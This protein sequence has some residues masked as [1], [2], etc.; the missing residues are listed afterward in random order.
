[1]ATAT[2]PAPTTGPAAPPEVQHVTQYLDPSLIVRDACNARETDPAP[3][4]KL[5]NSVKTLGVQEPISV[6]P[7]GDGTYGA[8]KGWRRA[9]A[10]Q[11]ANDTAADEQREQRP[12]PA[13]VHGE[14]VG[15]DDWTRFLSLVENDH[16]EGMDAR[17]TLKAAELSLVGMDEVQRKV[18]AKAL[19]LGR[20]A[21]QQVKR[22]QKLT[23]AELRRASAGGMDL[24]QT[25]Q[26][27][28][29]SEIRNAERRLLA[30]LARDQEEGKGGR[31]HWDQEINA[32]HAEM[33]DN[34]KR[35]A[36]LQALKDADIPVL[37]SVYSYNHLPE[38]DRPR[39][40]SELMTNLGNTLTEEAH[41]GCAGHS[42]RLD[43]EHQPVWHCMEPAKYGHKVRPE[44]RQPKNKLSE[45]ERAERANTVARNR[46]WKAA[47]TMRQNYITALA[48]SSKALPE[49]A[50]VFAQTTLVTMPF[51]YAAFTD[52]NTV[53]E[54]APYLGITADSYDEAVEAIT[55]LPKSKTA[56]VMFAQVAAAYE[57][58]LRE[59]KAWASLHPKTAQWLLLL[60]ELGKADNGVYVL[61][62]V[63]AD[64]VASHR[65]KQK[66]TGAK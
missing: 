32:L 30:A 10:A 63:E 13:F 9:Q 56:H 11:I 36:A 34:T 40:L 31:G 58:A 1:M 57:Y 12:I 61:S 51:F 66:K 55:A 19:G 64:A 6:R 22:A 41:K 42:A 50:R 23:D 52:K 49:A 45:K 14:L 44:A 53:K 43:D 35:D 8:F 7:L 2:P 48:R 37:H 18:A 17:D 16:R 38:K 20:K 46:A 28:E 65:P 26:L 3:D 59:N 24:E 15:Q 29:V 5:I 33:A 25:A 62:E 60:E 39:P 54:I 21:A 4:D 27:A 47:R